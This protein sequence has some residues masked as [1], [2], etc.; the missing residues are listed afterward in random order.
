[1]EDRLIHSRVLK[2]NHPKTLNGSHG[3]CDICDKS[4]K[5]ILNAYLEYFILL[6]QTITYDQT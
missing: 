6:G 2:D 5:S 3:I 4:N 1:M